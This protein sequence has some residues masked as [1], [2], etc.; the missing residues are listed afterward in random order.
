[1]SDHPHTARDG[2]LAKLA[3]EAARFA[4][5]AHGSEHLAANSLSEP[6]RLVR[7]PQQTSH[8]SAAGSPPGYVP[9]AV[10]PERG[11][12]R[13]VV[14]VDGRIH[15]RMA[16]ATVDALDEVVL[17]W[18]AS[19]PSGLRDLERA[20]LIRVGIALALTDIA[21]RG[22]DGA[23]GE[24]IRAALDPATRH[25]D[26]PMPDLLRWLRATP[27]STGSADPSVAARPA[28][29]ASG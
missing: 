18:R 1:V 14:P 12:T 29:A 2:A 16:Q 20:T 11:N 9:V 4:A 15:M 7:A 19:D 6:A 24:A 25:T 17:S 28:A 21:E 3:A 27:T 5:G 22:R 26:R 8:T 23:V 13:P 10:A